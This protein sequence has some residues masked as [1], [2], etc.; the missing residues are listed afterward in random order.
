MF[1]IFLAVSVLFSVISNEWSKIISYGAA[2]LIHESG[3][4]ATAAIL[5]VKLY[6]A[7]MC[8]WGMKLRFDFYKTSSIKETIVSLAGSA[9]GILSSLLVLLIFGK[10]KVFMDFAI[11]SLSLSVLN[12][13]P[14][15]NLDGGQILESLL[16]R[17]LLPNN[18]LTAYT[19]ISGLFAVAFWVASVWVQ[20]KAGVNLSLLMISVYFLF[21]T[22][23]FT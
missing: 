10:N 5:G 23:V 22:L 7:A 20:F 3:H 2:I 8:P 17:Y 15:K 19:A 16:Y 6:S 21:S 4:L 14:I 11:I 13:L 12:L 18:A 1:I 9:V